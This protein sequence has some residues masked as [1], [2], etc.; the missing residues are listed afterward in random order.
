MAQRLTIWALEEEVPGSILGRANMET[1]FSKL[2][3]VWVFWV[4]ISHSGTY[5]TENLLVV[6]VNGVVVR[7]LREKQSDVNT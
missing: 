6:N 1:N 5:S 7:R 3:L 2:I 4:L